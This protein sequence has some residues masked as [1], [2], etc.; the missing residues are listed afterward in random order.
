MATP[1]VE[2]TPQQIE[3]AIH[4]ETAV[5]TRVTVGSVEV[6]VRPLV[7]RW[8]SLFAAAALPLLREE[9]AATENIQKAIADGVIDYTS[10]S[11]LLI[12]SELKS[13]EHL[14][15]AAAV[16]LASQIPGAEKTPDTVIQERIEWLKDNAHTEELRALVEAQAAKERLVEQVGE[17]LPARFAR[18]LHLAGRTDV[19]VDSLKQLLTSSWSRLSAGAGTGS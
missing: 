2:V 10:M 16:V 12:D 14:D 5:P 11:S 17:R 3:E 7:R 4:P 9:L 8:Q 13:D 19:T 15:R 6:E 1:A 18:L